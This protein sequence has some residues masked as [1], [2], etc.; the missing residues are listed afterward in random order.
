MLMKKI[1]LLLTLFVAAM[2]L[3]ATAESVVFQPCLYTD[4]SWVYTDDIYSEI[5]ADEDELCFTVTDFLG[6]GKSL[7]FKKTTN[8]NYIEG[9]KTRLEI[10]QTNNV[11]VGSTTYRY[12]EVD[13]QRYQFVLPADDVVYT[14]VRARYIWNIKNSYVEE[15]TDLEAQEK[16]YRYHG[17]FDFRVV[18]A[19]D[20]EPVD[21][22]TS[23]ETWLDV[24]FYYGY[25][26]PVV[27]ELVGSE[28]ITLNT[29]TIGSSSYETYAKPHETTLEKY[30]N[31]NTT[32]YT[33]KDFL[34]TGNDVDFTFEDPEEGVEATMTIAQSYY[35]D[36]VSYP[37]FYANG[38][39]FTTNL[40]GLDD[41]AINLS[42]L[43]FDTEATVYKHTEAEV[44]S[45]DTKYY[46]SFYFVGYDGS[47]Y[48]DWLFLD[49][50]FNGDNNESGIIDTLLDNSN[51]P[52]EYYNLNGIRVEN[53]ANGIYICKQGNNV[54]K[55]IIK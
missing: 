27:Y 19:S 32:K 3:K 28:K 30:V 50:Y 15:Y 37:Y 52:V 9:N 45:Y 18:L 43:Y 46:G 29:Y 6:S 21:G 36:G 24:D 12:L 16:G 5:T 13:S 47:A 41:S 1:L 42:Y 10:V 54:K 11:K 44:A 35:V 34:G 55:V 49:F 38:N 31:E 8:S 2:S 4:G 20:E 17:Y 25:V 33:I 48:T 40:V 23:V 22:D 26:E 51:A 53:P 7:E 14:T 39:Y